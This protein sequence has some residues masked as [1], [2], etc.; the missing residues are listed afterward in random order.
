MDEYPDSTPLI[1]DREALLRRLDEQGMLF[2]RRLLPPE[3]VLGVRERT[4]RALERAG[5]LVGDGDPEDA[6]PGRPAVNEGDEEFFDA[7]RD[8]QA[9]EVF[10]ALAHAAELTT[11]MGRLVG[12]DL[13]VH[14]RKIARI[15]FP[16]NPRGTTPPHQ[17]YRYIQGTTDV[18]TSWVPLGACSPEL[19]GLKVL[20]GSH[21][22]GLIPAK[23]NEDLAVGIEVDTDETDPDWATA[24]YEPGDVIV[25]HSLTV[26]GALPNRTGKLRLSA[27]YRYQ[28]ANEPLVKGSLH[29]H[30]HPRIPDWPELVTDWTSLAPVGMPSEPELAEFMPVLD[31]T[32]TVE[33]SKYFT[34]AASE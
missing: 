28:S 19:G 10:H 22:R 17:D 9:G 8:L 24:A 12:D 27:D 20:R 32:T 21:R 1:G 34:F 23:W 16:D 7:Y 14:P 31:P 15:S 6:R 13:T 4:L 2:F 33:P 11:L 5:W 30:W 25:F 3:R 18:F 29:P 26:H